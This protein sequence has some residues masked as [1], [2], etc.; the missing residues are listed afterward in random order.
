MYLK[1]KWRENS[2]FSAESSP[3]LLGRVD[4]DR[5]VALIFVMRFFDGLHFTL[6]A[7]HGFEQLGHHDFPFGAEKTISHK[8]SKSFASAVCARIVVSINSVTDDISLFILSC[9]KRR[10]WK[11]YFC[12]TLRASHQDTKSNA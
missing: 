12:L 9:E 5:P 11:N 2:V 7:S 4:N 1:K 3:K 6:Q 10:K 8:T